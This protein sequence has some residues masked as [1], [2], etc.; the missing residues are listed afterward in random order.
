MG[1]DQS[2]IDF[3]Q[4]GRDCR[5]LRC[6]KPAEIGARARRLRAAGPPARPAS[7]GTSWPFAPGAALRSAPFPPPSR[8]RTSTRSAKSRRSAMC[9]R[10]CT[11]GWCA[12]SGTARPSSR[13][14]IEVVPTW[15]LD[16]HDVL[17]FVMAAGRQLQRRL[18]RARRAGLGAR[19][20]QAALPYRRIGRRGDRL[21]GRI[22]GEALEGRR[23]GRRPLQPG[24][25][26]RRG[27]QRRRP[28]VLRL[29]A[30]LGLRDAGRLLRP[31]LPGAGP[32]ADGAPA[33]T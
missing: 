7:R 32:P 20:P 27:V 16:S 28:D 13:C 12:R 3:A 5:L 23:R 29:A 1:R 8:R 24:R 19:R 22:E 30:H 11:P 14:R 17:V 10:R 21:G 33:S 6:N 18:G 9:R 31:V 15:P 4:P 2:G 25:R 26:R